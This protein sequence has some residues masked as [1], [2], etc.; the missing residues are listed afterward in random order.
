MKWPWKRE[1]TTSQ[2]SEARTDASFPRTI[3]YLTEDAIRTSALE[4]AAGI[5]ANAL[6][7]AAG[8]LPSHVLAFIGREL[9]LRGQAILYLDTSMGVLRFVPV[10]YADVDGSSPFPETW[11]YRLNVTSPDAS[12]YVRVSGAGVVHLLWACDPVQP[13]KGI[14]PWRTETASTLGSMEGRLHRESATP[15]GYLLPSIDSTMTEDDVKETADTL[16]LSRLNGRLAS[17]QGSID[18]SGGEMVTGQGNP[19]QRFTPT[20]LGFDPPQTMIQLRKDVER[21]VLSCCQ[22]P[23]SLTTDADGTSQ[24]ESYRR[25]VVMA[26]EPVLRRLSGELEVK[27]D[28][29]PQ[30][31]SFDVHALHGHDIAGRAKAFQVLVAGGKSAEEA[32]RLAGLMVPD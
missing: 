29:T 31:A 10:W 32:S 21:S 1:A 6:A 13:W 12:Q 5:W 25:F 3:P 9:I 2:H 17:V 28:L 8:P 26:V 4:T 30:Q 11:T 20:R 16:N 23:P 24:R 19:Q 22:I 18:S 7:S 15:F 27:L 14:P